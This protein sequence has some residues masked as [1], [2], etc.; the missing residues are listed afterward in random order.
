MRFRDAKIQEIF[1]RL[2]VRG[3]GTVGRTSDTSSP[4]TL[5][6]V[7]RLSRDTATRDS[8]APTLAE[9]NERNRKFWNPEPDPPKKKRGTRDSATTIIT[10]ADL[11]K[12]NQE[13]WNPPEAA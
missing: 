10:L 6:E 12:R 9:L 11:N 5:A 3:A 13:F 2:P 1:D 4:L 8:S 7:E